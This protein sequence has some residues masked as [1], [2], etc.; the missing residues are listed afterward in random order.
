MI[1]YLFLK[2]ECSILYVWSQHLFSNQFLFM[3]K[4]EI[5]FTAWYVTLSLNTVNYVL[6]RK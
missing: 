4:Y 5:H 1:E 3:Y 2:I 6:N